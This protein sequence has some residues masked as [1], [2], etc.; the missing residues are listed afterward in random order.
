MVSRYLEDD[1]VTAFT[2]GEGLSPSRLSSCQ[3][4]ECYLLG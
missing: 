2:G 4:L 3:G 1:A